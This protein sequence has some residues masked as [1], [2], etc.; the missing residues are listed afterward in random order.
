MNNLILRILLL[1]LALGSWQNVKSCDGM[2]ATVLS[3]VYMGN[4]Q[5]QVTV[6]YCE[7]VSNGAGA[8]V[9][10]IILQSSGAGTIVGTTTPSF[11]SNSTGVTIN[12]NQING[13]TIQWGEWD[14]NPNVPDFLQNGNAT[15]CFTMVL[16][17]NGPIT[18]I[19]ISGSSS[20][21][22]LGA[23]FVSWFGR[24]CCKMTITVPPVTCNSTWT[25][26]Q[27][28][29]GSGPIN[30][31]STSSLTGV[32]SG[33]GVNSATGIFTPSS[34][35]LPAAITFTVGDAGLNC[36]TTLNITSPYTI[37]PINDQT[38]CAGQSVSLVANATA[39]L[40]C[41]YVLNLQDSYGDGWQGGASVSVYINGVFYG[42]YTLASGASQNINIPVSTGNVITL[43]YTAGSSW[44]SENRIRILNP[45]GTAI[46][47]SAWG[48]AS[49]S[50][51]GGITAN[52]GTS[53]PYTYSWSPAAGLSN[54]AIANPVATPT[55]TTTYTVTA[56]SSSG[57][58]LTEPVTIT[59]QPG[60]TP[61]FNVLAPV[62]QNAPAPVLLTTST[63]GITGTWSPATISTISVGSTNYTFTPSGGACSTPYSFTF[64]VNPIPAVNA[65]VDQSICTGNVVTLAATGATTYT[66]N[67]GVVQG[68]SYTPIAT[69]TYT[70][71]GTGTGGCT[72]T[73]QVLITVN[74]IP[75]T[76]AGPDVAICS[77]Q[78]ILLTA[79]GAGSYSWSPGGQTTSSINVSPAVTTNYTVTGT[80][81][82]CTSTD[83]VIVS[84]SANAAINAGAD[85]THCAGQSTILTA[86]GGST[87]S[88]DNGLGIGNNI[89]VSPVSTTTYIVIGTNA[90]GC[91]GT[92][93]ITVTVNPIPAVNAGPDVNI[94]NSG[95]TTLTASGAVSY[96]WSPGGQN[97]NSITVS[98]SSATI[99]T[100]SGTSLGCTS[101]D[102]VLVTVSP[103]AIIDA[104]PDFAICIAESVTLS[105]SGG[106][107]YSWDNSLGNGN[108]FN[109]SPLVTTIYNV[110]GT[111]A[112]GCI[113]NDQI[114]VIVN[115]L[116][117]VDAGFPQII[118]A[119]T[120]VTLTATGANTYTWDNNLIQG[121][122]LIPLS[123]TTYSVTGTSTFG[124]TNTDNVLVTVNPLPIVNAGIDQIACV[125]N[126]I[127]LNGLGATVYA[128][129]NGV[130]DGLA[131]NPP[132]GTTTYTVSATDANG[133]EGTDQVLVTI[134]PLPNVNAGNDITI[135][136]GATA[137]LTGSG[138]S[139]YFWNNGITNGATF[140]PSLGT[141][142]YTLT[143]TSN[144]GCVNTDQVDVTV[145]P[146][147]TASFVPGNSGCAPLTSNFTSTS[148]NSNSC[149][150]TFSNGTTISGCGTIP[151]TFNQAGC[152][153]VTLT[154]TSTQGCIATL[155][156]LD[157][158]C[159]EANPIAEFSPSSNELPNTNTLVDFTNNS[160]DASSYFWNFGSDNATSTE[161]N[162]SFIYPDINQG[163]YV[164]M[165]VA[166]SPFGCVDTAYS[167]INVYEELI[168]YV[169][170]TFT[171]DLDNFNPIFKPIFTSGFDPR[172]FVLY[173]YN[174]W[175]ELIFESHD[176]AIGWDGSYGSNR[177]IGL[178]QDGTYTW[179]I[180]FKTTR[181]DERK[182]YL[183]HVNVIR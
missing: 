155:T 168:F 35:T 55:T 148:I 117:I 44:N 173:V 118:C 80:S 103:N 42:S 11:T 84:V 99:Y 75:V 40:P 91:I 180:E 34:T 109:V 60:G 169:P 78:S 16:N 14:D 50:M 171:P 162:P 159:V 141:T 45:S 147:P 59:V 95:S 56:T 114:T 39:S 79:S 46:Y 131:F 139:T 126:S 61:T 94:C 85:V 57:C 54:P 116:P 41:N 2:T 110:T 4:N 98:P 86:T 90:G 87:Y 165:L 20:S 12:Y 66:W 70:V 9:S 115:Q 25:P 74:P 145:N 132:I 88:W 174:R 76:N 183:G 62:C 17:T 146:N 134:S 177:E 172:D 105:A 81:L 125:G 138:A 130:T 140:F 101:S 7:S 178:C 107:S 77:G 37:A 64:V 36:S 124:C 89:N 92:D 120:P 49:G 102:D 161:A 10:G 22:N 137:L 30:L 33:P 5:Y 67:S 112:D 73:D 182:V 51:G 93:A 83:V 23:G 128:W 69:N 1:F 3:N 144:A 104:G 111:S 121:V 135:C 123:T 97:T 151:V 127:T 27:I 47:T 160:V 179:K 166:T 29:P 167:T 181:N 13:N 19:A 150:W 158:I 8:N 119:N 31:N 153:D 96:T 58:V 154:A 65:G 48:P 28:C 164:V 63:N 149:V 32:F 129:T 156:S 113:G 157:I 108:N 71:T 122:P 176:S 68:V 136:E 52:C 106:V 133:C 18:S 15:Q 53:S 72:N 100:V 143:G 175:G 21:S 43:N 82:G 170:N 38:I 152:Y 6:Q 24:W 26:P 142:T 163:S